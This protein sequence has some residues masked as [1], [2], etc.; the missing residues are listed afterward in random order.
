MVNVPI[1]ARENEM[2]RR[3]YPLKYK[4]RDEREEISSMKGMVNNR[5]RSEGGVPAGLSWKNE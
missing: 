3:K 1:T 2:D 5:C 4:S